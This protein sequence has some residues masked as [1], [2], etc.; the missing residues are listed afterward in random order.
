MS[1]A[2]SS[3]GKAIGKF[4][5]AFVVNSSENRVYW[6]SDGDVLTKLTFGRE[7]GIDRRLWS[8]IEKLLVMRTD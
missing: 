1:T 5:G 3:N 6:V 8:M 2:Y 4:D 7:F